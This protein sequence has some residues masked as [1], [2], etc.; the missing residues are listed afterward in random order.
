MQRLSNAVNTNRM[1]NT[2]KQIQTCKA[3]QQMSNNA[4]MLKRRLVG[5]M[6]WDGMWWDE[7]RWNAVGFVDRSG[8]DGGPVS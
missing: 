4:K 1:L 8:E 5:W 6:W 2:Y 3:L 7:I